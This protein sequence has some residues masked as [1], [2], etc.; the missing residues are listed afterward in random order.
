MRSLILLLLLYPQ[1]TPQ[2]PDPFRGL[3]KKVDLDLKEVDTRAAFEALFKQADSSL[4]LPQDFAE[5]KISYRADG[6]PFW[7]AVDALCRL[8][9]GLRH[10][11]HPFKEERELHPFPWVEYPATYKGPLRLSIFDAA[12][13]REV[14]YP[15]RADR[16]DLALI[17]QWAAPFEPIRGS[18]GRAGDI[19]LLRVED[20]TGRPLLPEIK[21]P[22]E[23]EV[24]HVGWNST[25]ACFWIRHLQPASAGAKR[26]ARID[27]EWEGAFLKDVEE[28][29]FDNPAESVGSA[30]KI[31]PMTLVLASFAKEKGA[32]PGD[33]SSSYEFVLRLSFDPSLAP[34]EWQDSLQT[35]PLSKRVIASFQSVI[36]TPGQGQR[37]K[38]KSLSEGKIQPDAVEL[39]GSVSLAAENR[40]SSIA[41]RVAKGA[42]SAKSSFSFKDV[43]LPE[44]GR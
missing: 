20:D 28:V 33:D 15:G 5:R 29:V 37:V 8:N 13:I 2:E 3:W 35:A 40:L 39:N 24:G 17:L 10:P 12:R 32:L 30:K 21:V 38:M 7:Q 31:G 44:E 41:V 4:T 34:K 9:G 23:F 43:K 25:P 19:R 6:V 1:R 22:V 14:R 26:I 18:L 27:A 11:K 16:T 42:G 36:L